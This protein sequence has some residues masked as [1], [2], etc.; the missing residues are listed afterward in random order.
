MRTIAHTNKRTHTPQ[1][2]APRMHKRKPQHTC[3]S[4]N[5]LVAEKCLQPKNPLFAASGE[6]CA[7]CP[8]QRNNISKSITLLLSAHKHKNMP[9]HRH[10]HTRA[11]T[12]TH[13]SF[14]KWCMQM[15]P[16]THAYMM[17]QRV[18]ACECERVIAHE[19]VICLYVK[20]VGVAFVLNR[21]G[22]SKYAKRMYTHV[23]K[24]T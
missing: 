16:R 5:A 14:N 19:S 23:F 24:H 7:V 11:S 10:T 17:L 18:P 12:Q 22:S 21:A 1:A 13:I 4:S 6:G 9:T 8:M 15:L 2:H 3:F 20:C